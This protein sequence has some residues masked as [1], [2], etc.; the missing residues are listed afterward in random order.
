M[1]INIWNLFKFFDNI[2]KNPNYLKKDGVTVAV[3]KIPGAKHHALFMR[4]FSKFSPFFPFPDYS[5]AM[6]RIFDVFTHQW[7]K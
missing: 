3:F 4:F 7:D 5:G 1:Y 2:T 6:A